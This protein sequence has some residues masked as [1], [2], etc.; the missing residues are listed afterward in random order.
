M[1]T[2]RIDRGRELMISDPIVEEIRNAREEFARLFNYDLNAMIEEF[3]RRQTKG[4]PQTVSFPP[5][6][7]APVATSSHRGTES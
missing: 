6:R 5:K 7:L 1:Y 2:G 3:Q 4:G